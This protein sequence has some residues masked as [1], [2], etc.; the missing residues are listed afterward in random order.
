[1]TRPRPLARIAPLTDLCRARALFAY[2]TGAEAAYGD[3]A[4]PMIAFQLWR[5]HHSGLPPTASQ[6]ASIARAEELE[7]LG[8][9]PERRQRAMG[10]NGT[11]TAAREEVARRQR[12]RQ[13]G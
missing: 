2:N 13:Q 11:R 3:D 1:M 6:A 7:R 12:A 10:R 4:A 5:L 8:G 9:T